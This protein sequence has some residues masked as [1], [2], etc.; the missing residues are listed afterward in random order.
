[1]NISIFHDQPINMP[2]AEDINISDVGSLDKD[3]AENIYL[4]DCMDFITPLQHKELLD[5]LH[6]IIKENGL[7]YIQ[8][9]DLK[10]IMIAA[11]FNKINMQLAQML[12]YNKRVFAHTAQNIKDILET[13][14]YITITQ[15]YINIFEYHFI[16]KKI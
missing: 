5:I 13:S 10:Q 3:I 6:N 15:K 9:P 14:N 11:T 1:M 8:A 16:F 4:N 12:L 2:N 7:L